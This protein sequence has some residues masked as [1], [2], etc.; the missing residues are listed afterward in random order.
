VQLSFR[1]RK[2][3]DR[4]SNVAVEIQ[5]ISKNVISHRI[6]MLLVLPT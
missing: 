5:Y 4:E 6:S 2:E 3:A 1:L